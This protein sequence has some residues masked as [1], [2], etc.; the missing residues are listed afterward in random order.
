MHRSNLVIMSLYGR[1]LNYALIEGG[2]T[3]FLALQT[4]PR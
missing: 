4:A 1:L 2:F 3:F